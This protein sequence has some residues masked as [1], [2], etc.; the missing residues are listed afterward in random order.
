M[1]DITQVM[2]MD[3]GQLFL[4]VLTIIAAILFV[5][6]LLE[7]FF[8][9]IGRPLKWI[10]KNDTDHQLISDAMATIK[11]MQ[12]THAADKKEVNDKNDKLEQALTDFMTEVRNDIKTFTDNRLNDRAQSL[13]IQQEWT[14][15]IDGVFDK[16]E[17]MQKQTDERFEASEAKTNKRVQS[18]IKQQIAQ[19]FRR[20]DKCKKISYMEL[21]ALEDLIDTYENYGG[22]NSFVHSVVQ[23]EMYKWEVTGI[24]PED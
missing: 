8:I 3:F 23:K 7:K 13:A 24:E 19:S 12:E 6:T 5:V 4:N 11:S 2:H 16:L 15:K 9:L 20:Y 22:D 1:N 14:E 18:D 10:K 21:E 17:L